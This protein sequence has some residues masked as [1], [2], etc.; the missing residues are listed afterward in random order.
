MD[1]QPASASTS[2]SRLV[3]PKIPPRPVDPPPARAFTTPTTPV[4]SQIRPT[5]VDPQPARTYTAPTPVDPSTRQGLVDRRGD[6]F[7][8]RPYKHRFVDRQH[9]AIT[10]MCAILMEKSPHL[11]STF[12]S[13]RAGP[14]KPTAFARLMGNVKGWPSGILTSHNVFPAKRG[15]CHLKI[16]A[17]REK[18]RMSPARTRSPFNSHHEG[19]SDHHVP[20]TELLCESPPADRQSA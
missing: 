9:E 6:L 20:I 1:L 18:F 14:A 3:D 7:P 8:R 17:K 10:N 16:G 4:V 12:A 5:L 13:L 2:H 11:S 19:Y 15:H